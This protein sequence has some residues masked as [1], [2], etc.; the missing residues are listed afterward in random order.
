MSASGK[1]RGSDDGPFQN[2]GRVEKGETETAL[3]NKRELRGLGEAQIRSHLETVL[4]EFISRS[5][6]A[7]R[8][9][10]ISHIKESYS[11]IVAVNEDTEEIIATADDHHSLTEMLLDKDYDNENTLIIRADERTGNNQIR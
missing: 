11:G 6:N 10:L 8:N 7:D 4:E 9:R 1:L 3:L 5:H 2:G